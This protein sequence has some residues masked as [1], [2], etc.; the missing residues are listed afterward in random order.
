[1][2]NPMDGI[3]E[4]TL[5]AAISW[6]TTWQSLG[7]AVSAVVGEG[8]QIE[9]VTLVDPDPTKLGPKGRYKLLCLQ[10]SVPD[11][12]LFKAALAFEAVC[13]DEGTLQ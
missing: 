8:G 3:A 9:A 13:M 11:D 2:I 1:M 5:H 6:L 12:S 7:G 10:R 4:S